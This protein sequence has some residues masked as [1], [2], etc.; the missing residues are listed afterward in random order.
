MFT[1]GGKWTLQ[2]EQRTSSCDG[3]NNAHLLKAV[4]LGMEVDRVR[5]ARSNYAS[6]VRGYSSPHLGE[7]AD[8]IG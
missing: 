8:Q 1:V 3:F 4:I 7:E 6:A 2:G 5:H